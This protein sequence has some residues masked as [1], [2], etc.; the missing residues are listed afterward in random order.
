M[1]RKAT[2]KFDDARSRLP[3]RRGV[4]SAGIDFQLR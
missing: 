3:H 1:A 4:G 2:S